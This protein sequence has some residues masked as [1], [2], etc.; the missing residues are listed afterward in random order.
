[1]VLRALAAMAQ[2]LALAGEEMP[3]V[4]VDRPLV[5]VLR[6]NAWHHFVKRIATLTAAGLEM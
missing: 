1:M 3:G 6:D 2:S 4:N 5:A